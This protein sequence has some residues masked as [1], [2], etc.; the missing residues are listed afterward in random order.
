MIKLKVFLFLSI[1]FLIN[2]NKTGL[3]AQ[4][5]ISIGISAQMLN[6]RFLV[7]VSNFRTKGAYRPT[8]IFFT[9]YNFGKRYCVHTGLG[10]SMMTQNSDAFRNNFNYLVMPLYL[11]KGRLKENQ[12]IAFASFFGVNLHYL[13]KAQHIFLDETKMDIMDQSRKFHFDFVVGGGLKFKLSD[14]FTLEA[15]TDFSLGYFVNK[16][17]AANMDINNFNTGLMLNLSYK[18]K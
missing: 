7:N 1:S 3:F 14:N 18:L 2:P 17:N 15:L 4:E 16:R 5:K 12:R 9:E 8:S 10:Y 11:K 6:T 13:L